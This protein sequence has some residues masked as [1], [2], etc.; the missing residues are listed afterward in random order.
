MIIALTFC[1]SCSGS[2]IRS[3]YTMSRRAYS[4]GATKVHNFAELV[5]RL[6]AGSMF[7]SVI[8]VVPTTTT[9][10]E[11]KLSSSII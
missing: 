11:R 10:V 5:A 1:S 2:L 3:C 9:R 8:A 7:T 4:V 6:A